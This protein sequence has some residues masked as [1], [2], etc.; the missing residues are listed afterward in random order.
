ML[1]TPP[2]N[3]GGKDRRRYGR[4]AAAVFVAPAVLRV[5]QRG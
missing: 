4:G 2:K 5:P 3:T 1:G